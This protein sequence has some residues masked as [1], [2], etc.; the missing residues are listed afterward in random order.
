MVS[1]R[2]FSAY[3]ETVGKRVREGRKDR[4][5]TQTQLAEVANLSTEYLSEIENNRKQVSLIALVE[6]S[7]CP[8]YSLDELLY[9]DCRRKDADLYVV[10]QVLKGCSEFERAVIL[11]GIR[12]LKQILKENGNLR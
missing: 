8:G 12:S 5:M 11:K 3:F 9:G 7:K 6:I 1:A 4:R 2:L 10:S